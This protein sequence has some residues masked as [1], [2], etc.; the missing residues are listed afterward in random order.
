MPKVI[1][2][3]LAYEWTN[4]RL[5]RVRLNN[6]KDNFQDVMDPFTL[7]DCFAIQFSTFLIVPVP[8]IG[9]SIADQVTATINRLRLNV[10][11]DYV[12]E[13]I[14]AVREYCLDRVDLVS[15]SQKYPFIANQIVRQ[16]FDATYKARFA[17][18]FRG[19]AAP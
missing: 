8:G 11:N 10:D 19:Q 13:R 18:F 12:Q 2:S 9:Q 5:C 1:N 4:F 3:S 17:A 6:L 7:P 15:L 14:G 16:G